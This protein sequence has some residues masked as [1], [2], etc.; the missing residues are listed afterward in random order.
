[1]ADKVRYRHVIA[2]NFTAA[3]LAAKEKL[4]FRGRL[5]KYL[6][7]GDR[8]IIHL[9]LIQ[10]RTLCY[11]RDILGI[12]SDHIIRKKINSAIAKH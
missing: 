1:M 11:I 9:R 2:K 7:A 10:Q 3:E 8:R 6:S 5:P 12:D 4:R